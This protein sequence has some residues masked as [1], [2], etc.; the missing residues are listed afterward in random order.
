M[1]RLR[2]LLEITAVFCGIA[3]ALSGIEGQRNLEVRIAASEAR[4]RELR[5][6]CFEQ[7]TLSRTM[8]GVID[9]CPMQA[10][11]D[12]GFKSIQDRLL[13]TD[14]VMVI[15]GPDNLDTIRR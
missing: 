7:A 11:V 5:D 8:T 1:G 3:V 9:S 4:V 12:A 6:L 13:P 2:I 10:T 15:S 14:P